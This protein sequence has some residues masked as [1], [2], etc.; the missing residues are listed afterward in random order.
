MGKRDN[1]NLSTWNRPQNS[2]FWLMT[3]ITCCR[4]ARSR[5][6]E[7]VHLIISNWLLDGCYITITSAYERP[8]SVQ[9]RRRS[10]SS[11]AVKKTPDRCQS[12][13]KLTIQVDNWLRPIFCVALT[14]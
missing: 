8:V 14:L 11:S 4:Y 2:T 7:D 6:L 12:V 3:R 13:F 5:C 1:K 9:N 10:P